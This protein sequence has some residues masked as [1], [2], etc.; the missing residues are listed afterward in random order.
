MWG[1]REALFGDIAGGTVTLSICTSKFATET[2]LK[3]VIFIIIPPP[4]CSPIEFQ[5]QDCF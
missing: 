5:R 1:F 2:P 4:S 3:K